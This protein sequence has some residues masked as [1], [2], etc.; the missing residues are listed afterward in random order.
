MEGPGEMFFSDLDDVEDDVCGL[1]LD[2][3]GYE[4]ANVFT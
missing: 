3:S 1:D 2:G 4:I